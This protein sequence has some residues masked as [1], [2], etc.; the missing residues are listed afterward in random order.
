MRG[1]GRFDIGEYL[2]Q[3][4]WDRVERSKKNV[5][6]T[7]KPPRL[8]KTRYCRYS[9][10]PVL[11]DMIWRSVVKGESTAAVRRKHD[12]GTA[13]TMLVRQSNSSCGRSGGG[14]GDER[15]EHY[16]SNST[17]STFLP[18]QGPPLPATSNGYIGWRSSLPQLNLERYGGA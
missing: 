13:H 18:L 11:D 4:Q 15:G 10:D 3:L 9:R 12:Y 5:N 8:P 14:G 2:I 17:P 1:G 6:S 7:K 16:P